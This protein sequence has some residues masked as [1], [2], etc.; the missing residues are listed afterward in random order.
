MISSDWLPKHEKR[1]R[2]LVIVIG[3]LIAV[4]QWIRIIRRPAGGLHPPLGVGKAVCFE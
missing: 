3:I 4:S 2:V 1:L